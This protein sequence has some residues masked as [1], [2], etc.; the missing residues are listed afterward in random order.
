M[1]EKGKIAFISEEACL[2]CFEILKNYSACEISLH[3]L[4]IPGFSKITT[5]LVNI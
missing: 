4:Y 5:M 1:G 3:L 2:S